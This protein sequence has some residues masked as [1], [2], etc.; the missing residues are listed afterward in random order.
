M[1]TSEIMEHK[2]PTKLRQLTFG[3]LLVMCLYGLGVFISE[4]TAVCSRQKQSGAEGHLASESN[5]L[6][7]VSPS[8]AVNATPVVALLA[9]TESNRTRVLELSIKRSKSSPELPKGQSSNASCPGT[10]NTSAT[11]SLVHTSTAGITHAELDHVGLEGPSVCDK[12]SSKGLQLKASPELVAAVIVLGH[13]RVNTL[14]RCMLHLLYHWSKDAANKARFPLFV[15]I[16]GG[17]QRSLN[18]AAAWKETAGV[19]VISRLHNPAVCSNQACKLSAHYKMLMQLF[20]QCLP[21]PRIIF[22][23]EDLQVS[24]SIILVC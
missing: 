16:D 5:G 24:T 12:G 8:P 3:L 4:Y 20:F 15:S 19:Q 9:T 17:D 22:L 18:F 14:A 2:K 1:V 11:G 23:E 21:T 7:V 10:A 13:K 6:A